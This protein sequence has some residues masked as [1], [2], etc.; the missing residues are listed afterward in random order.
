MPKAL[1]CVD[2][3]SSPSLFARGKASANPWPFVLPSFSSQCFGSPLCEGAPLRPL[4]RSVCG[5]KNFED[6]PATTGVFKFY[7]TIPSLKVNTFTEALVRWELVES[8]GKLGYT[9]CLFLYWVWD[10]CG[11]L[12]Q[13][14]HSKMLWWMQILFPHEPFWWIQHQLRFGKLVMSVGK[15]HVPTNSSMGVCHHFLSF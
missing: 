9:K 10:F 12:H 14:P 8:W 1:G 4:V 13:V 11:G 7:R 5:P 6:E 15:S 2:V 3:P